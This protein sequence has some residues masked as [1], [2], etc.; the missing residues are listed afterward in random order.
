MANSIITIKAKE[1]IVK[2]RANVAPIPIIEGMAFGNGGADG[3]D[4]IPPNIDATELNNELIRKPIELVTQ[5]SSTSY[6]Y[7]CTLTAT[8]IPNAS[9]SEIGFYDTDG[10][11]I[12]IRSFKPKI[13]DAEIDMVFEIEDTF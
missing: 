1:K 12:A 4:V 8:D 6:K 13:K 10:D 11:I 7:K 5:V 2:A 9:V 3:N